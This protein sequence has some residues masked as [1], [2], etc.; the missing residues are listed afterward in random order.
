MS[1]DSF[2]GGRPGASFVLKASFKSVGEMIAA[3]SQ[4]SSYKNVWYDEYCL[5]DT[6]NKNHPDNGKIFRRGL[7]YQDG[8]GGAI[9]IG[10]IV[11]PSSGTPY[12][13]M[14]TLD[15]V[16]N[17]AN[18][19]LND[20]EYK[21]YPTGYELDD[22]GNVVGYETS[23]G[24][25][26]KELATFSF[27]TAHDTSLVPGKIVNN[28]G[29]ISY[30]DDI[31]WTWCNIRKDNA[32]ADSWFYVGFEIPYMVT[33]YI[34][35]QTSGYD[36]NGNIL[37]DATDI[38]RVDDGKHPFYE[39]WDLGLPKGVKG[40][41]LRSL[42]VI[43]PKSSDKIYDISSITIDSKTGHADLS[44]LKEYAG[45]ADDIAANR[46]IVVFDYYVYDKVINPTPIMLYL[47]D[48]NIITGINVSDDGT[49]TVQYTHE[50]NSVFERKI[51]WI[52][53]V[54]L[55]TGNG[56]D[57]GHFKV[58]YNNGTPSYEID[59]TWIK[60]IEIQEDGTVVYTYAGAG[61][62][63]TNHET[64]IKT[65]QKLLKWVDAI[66]LNENTG[67]FRVEYNN[68][69]PAFETT[70]DW[71]KK[72]VLDDDGTIHFLHTK[73]GVDE[74]LT[75][76]LKW[77]TGVDLVPSTGKFTMNFNYGDPLERQLDWVDDI[78]INEDTGLMQIHH[79]NPALGTEDLDAK[80]KLITS[81]SVDA[82]GVTTFYCNTGESFTLKQ[83][84]S[85]N[86]YH[87]KAIDTVTLNTATN[88]DKHI[89]IKYNTDDNAV[90]IGDPINYI[91]DMVVRDSDFHLL[92]LFND[93][94][95][96]A[97]PGDLDAKGIALNVP[98]SAARYRYIYN[99]GPWINGVT[100]SSGTIYDSAIYWR[101]YGTIKDQS[102]VLIGFNVTQQTVTDALGAGGDILDYLNE[103]YPAG[104]TEG[105]TKQKI[106]TYSVNDSDD[107]KFY[108]YDY[109]LGKW[110]YLG[111][112]ADSGMRDAKLAIGSITD[113]DRST[114]SSDG[115]LLF[116][117]NFTINSTQIPRYWDANYRFVE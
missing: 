31:T 91:Q 53:N 5:I 15:E 22:S 83:S 69:S 1:L 42:K 93:P 87:I 60:G 62:S 30:K 95:H 55:T 72:I 58:D 29:S 84:G 94:E 21:R 88:E 35:H 9:L 65:I 63:Q 34:I 70:L 25:N 113:N 78:Y 12:F 47:G 50:D 16:K 106:V 79:V 73:D 36:N 112:I 39:K 76:Q 2:Y 4:G 103:N 44:K 19:S 59:L 18:A 71:I 57:G 102:G 115:I 81:A 100:S 38:E 86:D 3:F 28:D 96:R 66:T 107:K 7:N 20:Y 77:I 6:P 85:T 101:D 74:Q 97:Q 108:A 61:D 116:A 52:T 75:N 92:V 117:Q 98:A 49:L 110:Y 111:T 14:G 48:F 33:D 23:D 104:L 105:A 45:K 13:Q 17:Q 80:L 114:V 37:V 54:S 8:N 26:G 90:P 64:G 46:K 10:S 67:V 27:S 51:K 82:T 43:I 109:N 40:D 32:D 56:K 99:T 24:S 89:F 68:N 41:T 11:G